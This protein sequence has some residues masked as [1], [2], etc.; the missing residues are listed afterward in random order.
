MKAV[1]IYETGTGDVLTYEDVTKPEIE[2]DSLL[3][4]VHAAALNPV[5]W[6]LRSADSLPPWL[7][8]P[9]ILGWDVSGV[10]EESTSDL[11]Q[12]G[13]EVYGMVNFPGKGGAY[14]EYV[15]APASHVAHKP[16]T[17]N[18]IAASG[19]P[20]AALTAYQ[21][22][23]LSQLSA[24]QRVL[25]HAGAGGVGHFAIQLAKLRG[26]Y[27][28]TTA[29]DYNHDFLQDLG[30]DE[31][32]DYR[33]VDFETV[34]SDVDVVLQTI[35]GTHAQKSVTTLRD[36]GTLVI[37]A[38]DAEASSERGIQICP[39]LVEP[40]AAQLKQF[41]EWIDSGQLKVTIQ[42]TFALKDIASAHAKLEE[43]HTR[44]KN[45]YQYR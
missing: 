7:E 37:I 35:G 4:K 16:E 34:V 27:V 15:T 39:M 43:G 2:A 25:I 19:I 22:F 1:R 5:D 28:I 45:R 18:H 44:G 14:A 20:L 33:K 29:S 9:A 32:I 13:D 40:D 17:I 41:T 3:I 42:E 12:P 26:A 10:V 30:A 24:G 6:K 23:E 36:G 38:G 31:V 21:A 8:L 11:F